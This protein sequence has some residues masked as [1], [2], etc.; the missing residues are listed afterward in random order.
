[1]AFSEKQEQAI[2]LLAL[3]GKKKKDI[4]K[5]VGVAPVTLRT[6]QRDPEF[7]QAVIDLSYSLLGDHIPSVLKSLADKAKEGSF[8]H[9]KLF[10]E[11]LDKVREDKRKHS[12]GQIVFSWDLGGNETC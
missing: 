3:G 12:Q 11:H 9:A 8:Q 2:N 10:L 7:S 1:M 4:A 5:E 6:W